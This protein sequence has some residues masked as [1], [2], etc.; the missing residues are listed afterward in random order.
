MEPSAIYCGVPQGESALSVLLHTCAERDKVGVRSFSRC[1]QPK[2]P[3]DIAACTN[4]NVWAKQDMTMQIG[5]KVLGFVFGEPKLAHWAGMWL[6]VYP[7]SCGETHRSR[8]LHALSGGSPQVQERLARSGTQTMRGPLGV[9]VHLPALVD[10]RKRGTGMSARLGFEWQ[11]HVVGL[12]SARDLMVMLHASHWNSLPTHALS[13]VRAAPAL[14][15]VD[16]L[17]AKLLSK[18]NLT[19][20][21]HR[22]ASSIQRVSTHS[23]VYETFLRRLD[24]SLQLLCPAHIGIVA[25][26]E[27]HESLLMLAN[28]A[29][30]L[31]I[32]DHVASRLMAGCS[33]KNERGR[34]TARRLSVVWLQVIDYPL[35]AMG[36]GDLDSCKRT[37]A[38]WQHF[39]ALTLT[40][41]G[42]YHI[43]PADLLAAAVGHN[44]SLV[45]DSSRI[46]VLA[47]AALDKHDQDYWLATQFLSMKLFEGVTHLKLP[48]AS[49]AF[50]WPILSQISDTLTA[51]SQSDIVVCM[52]HPPLA[53]VV[54][55][56][57]WGGVLELTSVLWPE[58][59]ST[60]KAMAERLGLAYMHVRPDI[61]EHATEWMLVLPGRVELLE[62][63]QRP[64]AQALV[65]AALQEMTAHVRQRRVQWLRKHATSQPSAARN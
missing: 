63:P 54:G 6:D 64:F 46:N 42:L 53:A 17:K 19:T 39:R 33:L 45:N 58:E 51:A 29:Q 65:L 20:P 1:G 24:S 61:L 21:W 3:A 49:F 16:N 60:A 18:H 55:L 56:P 11:M 40:A 50:L 44:A 38:T 62:R 35:L 59:G 26:S 15:A 22:N 5:S 34:G 47:V 10:E 2:P 28:M 57:P 4:K 41:H 32:P 31:N 25:G 37:S 27:L 36:G 7:G 48:N 23:D 12:S 52:S 9:A 30:W 13:D 8:Q 43:T 14:A